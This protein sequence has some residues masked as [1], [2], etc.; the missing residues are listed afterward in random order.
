[1]SKTKRLSLEEM[2]TNLPPPRGA[3]DTLPTPEQE[4]RVD[5]VI[6]VHH[7]ILCIHPCCG[8]INPDCVTTRLS[9]RRTLIVTASGDNRTCK[10]SVKGRSACH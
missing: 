4:E 6:R 8:D 10:T 3:C 7:S 9:C 2:E 1:M 5:H